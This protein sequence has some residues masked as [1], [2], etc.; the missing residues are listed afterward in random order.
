MKIVLFCHS[1]LS[2]WNNGN[3][4]FLRGL[5]HELSTRGHVVQAFEPENCW[6][7]QNLL[8]ETGESALRDVRRAY[9]TLDV[10]RYRPERLDLDRA[11]DGADLVLVHEWNE[12]ALV[13]TLGERRRRAGSGFKL[14]FHDTHHRAVSEPEALARLTLDDYDGVLAFGAVLAERY[15]RAGW[16]RRAWTFHEAADTRL[17]HPLPGTRRE[18]A[19]AWVGNWGD[20]E[21][22]AELEEFLLE[23][24]RALGLDGTVHG[25]RYPESGALAVT[26]AGLEYAGWLPNYRVPE[27]FGRHRVTVHVPRRPYARDLRGIPTIRVFEALACGIPLVCAPWTDSEGLF[28]RNDYLSAA[29]GAEMRAAMHLVLRDAEAANELARRGRETVLARHTCAH[30]VD[31]L[32]NIV[33]AL[34][35][36]TSPSLTERDSEANA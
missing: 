16:G 29:N 8:A 21:R 14:L 13:A 15:W 3:A 10:T 32:L 6:S 19:L 4:H 17:F 1:L 22:T 9:P 31:D 23:P 28:R 11:L 34:Q 26:Q 20:E 36:Y 5:A 27:V 24:A 7:M 12:P 33:R 35:T 30:R 25:V 2:D 18:R